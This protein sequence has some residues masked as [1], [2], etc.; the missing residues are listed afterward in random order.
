MPSSRR[1]CCDRE[2]GRSGDYPRPCRR[3]ARIP[4]SSG[5]QPA[6]HKP[7]STTRCLAFRSALSVDAGGDHGHVRDSAPAT[8]AFGA[9]MGNP[10]WRPGSARRR[11]LLIRG[12]FR[13]PAR[14]R[15]VTVACVRA[16][17]VLATTNPGSKR[18]D[19][20]S[21]RGSEPNSRERHRALSVPSPAAPWMP[22]PAND[23]CAAITTTAGE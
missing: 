2:P 13:L 9:E 11:S 14:L 10:S 20:S 7:L 22:S 23:H 5:V 17:C 21:H 18:A 12:G 6:G 16:S 19:Q 4:A 3:T 8:T 15:D 1:E